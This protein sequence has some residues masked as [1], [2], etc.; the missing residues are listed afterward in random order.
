MNKKSILTD[1]ASLAVMFSDMIASTLGPNGLSKLLV[2][3]TGDVYVT[4]ETKT[5]IDKIDVKHPIIKIMMQT[6]NTQI[7]E[8]GDGGATVIIITGELLRQALDLMNKGVMIPTIITGYK[9]ALKDALSILHKNEFSDENGLRKTLVTALKRDDELV[10]ALIKIKDTPIDDVIIISKKGHGVELIKGLAIDKEPPHPVMPTRIEKPRILITKTPIE[11]RGT[12]VKAE[13]KINNPSQ[14]TDLMKR[15]SNM[16]REI[17]NSIKESGANVVINQKG[18]SENAQEQLARAGIMA[19]RR[20]REHDIELIVKATGAKLVSDLSEIT[21]EDLG[22]AGLIEVRKIGD[23]KLTVLSECPKKVNTIIVKSSL[24]QGQDEMENTVRK[25]LMIIKE[26]GT[27]VPGAGAIETII[28]NELMKNKIEG[29]EQL[30]Y[31]SFG[32]AVR[33]VTDKLIRLTG[34]KEIE[35]APQLKNGKGVNTEGEIID[36]IKEE[37]IELSM[38]KEQALI[39]AAETTNTILRIDSAIKKRG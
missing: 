14:L 27:Y 2:D 38:I 12:E 26:S 33:S 29:R 22:S 32:K 7:S 5:I 30:A 19:L 20:V 9:K 3:S 21:K 23:E 24:K 34:R 28:G 37:V 6:A 1:N 31:E 13:F 17:T 8:T 15:E 10:D 4:N 18:I 16:I 35:L 11:I 25:G 36:P 39:S